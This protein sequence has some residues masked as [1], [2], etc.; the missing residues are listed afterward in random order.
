[1]KL[2]YFLAVVFCSVL[3]KIAACGQT[4]LPVRAAAITSPFDDP[5]LGA[6]VPIP[7]CVTIDVDKDSDGFSACAQKALEKVNVPVVANKPT[8]MNQTNLTQAFANLA[9]CSNSKSA[10]IIGHGDSGY[11]HVGG[12]DYFVDDE[13][14]Y[15]GDVQSYGTGSQPWNVPLWVDLSGSIKD[16][17]ET[18]FLL[19]CETG[20]TP[21][22]A[23]IVSKFSSLTKAHVKAPTSKVWCD[24]DLHL[25][26]EQG[27]HWTESEKDMPAPINI[28]SSNQSPEN[29]KFADNEQG[30]YDT[31]AQNSVR[32]ISRCVYNTPRHP[33]PKQD[34]RIVTNHQRFLQSIFFDLPLQPHAIPNAEI[35]G[36][37]I[38]TACPSADQPN[39]PC[40]TRVFDVLNDDLVADA[41][42]R[43]YYR[44]TAEFKSNWIGFD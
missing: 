13:T 38:I 17:F 26:L 31:F 43:T 18:I 11:I 9:G 16:K 21:Y 10:M 29:I 36:T 23:A 24:D 19:G 25:R 2:P 22:G 30:A 6:L 7:P 14:K 42:K 39:T 33:G 15:V 32:I 3:I 8:S 20:T 34:C 44:V 4:A 27:A 37:I 12:G 41:P 28:Q 5:V 1:M 40:Q 35:T